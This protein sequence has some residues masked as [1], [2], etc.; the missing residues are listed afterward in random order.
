MIPVSL[1]TSSL[2]IG[3]SLKSVTGV[4]SPELFGV[5][6]SDDPRN[7]PERSVSFDYLRI[8]AVLSRAL[9]LSLSKY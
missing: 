8:A 5:S 9:D 1:L 2:E 7:S 3:L 4:G 6:K